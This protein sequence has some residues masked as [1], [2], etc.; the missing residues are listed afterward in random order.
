MRAAIS[1]RRSTM[2]A[3]TV[4]PSM[5]PGRPGRSRMDSR[6]KPV[7]NDRRLKCTIRCT[8]GSL[9]RTSPESRGT[10]GCEESRNA[11]IA[12]DTQMNTDAAA[13]RAAAVYPS[14]VQ[15]EA[16]RIS[17]YGEPKFISRMHEVWRHA[18]HSLRATRTVQDLR[19]VFF[20]TLATTFS[21]SEIRALLSDGNAAISGADPPLLRHTRAGLHQRIFI[22]KS[23]SKAVVA[24]ANAQPAVRSDNAVRCEA[25]MFISAAFAFICVPLAKRHRAHGFPRAAEC[26]PRLRHAEGT[27]AR[28]H[29]QHST[30]KSAFGM[31]QPWKPG[32]SLSLAALSAQPGGPATTWYVA[33]MPGRR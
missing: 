10:V 23:H 14:H 18:G 32:R 12:D 28:Q 4:G 33:P 25:S 5:T 6:T 21:T 15:G 24:T 19:R 22:P 13:C 8:V 1:L 16:C 11:D 2:P 29:R 20:S 30:R 17:R 3:I 26:R 31:T 27:H 7:Q 9:R